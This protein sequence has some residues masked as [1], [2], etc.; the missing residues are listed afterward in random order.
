MLKNYAARDRAGRRGKFPFFAREFPMQG[1]NSRRQE[2]GGKAIT[3][4]KNRGLNDAE[5]RSA[6]GYQPLEDLIRRRN[7]KNI[8]KSTRRR[9]FLIG[10]SVKTA[11]KPGRAGKGR[12]ISSIVY[13]LSPVEALGKLWRR[14]RKTGPA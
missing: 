6:K 3:E 5:K 7:D 9:E 1:S 12:I 11:H 8:A 2:G 13:H 14:G 10:E 4:D